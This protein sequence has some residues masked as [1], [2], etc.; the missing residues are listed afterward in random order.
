MPDIVH[1]N[2][3]SSWAL[4]IMTEFRLDFCFVLF[5]FSCSRDEMRSDIRCG[6]VIKQTQNIS[7]RKVVRELNRRQDDPEFLIEQRTFLVDDSICFPAEHV[8]EVQ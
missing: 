4:G 3:R 6:N 8:L 7:Y 2:L 5:R 1:E